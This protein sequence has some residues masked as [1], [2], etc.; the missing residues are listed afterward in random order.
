MRHL[1]TVLFTVIAAPALAHVGHVGELAGH[2]HVV[3]GIALGAAVGIAI[4]G[5]IR[6]KKEDDAN[7]E[8]EADLESDAE[9]QEA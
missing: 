5:A 4:W 9:P 7:S 2:D 1:V 3:A 8:A 6:G